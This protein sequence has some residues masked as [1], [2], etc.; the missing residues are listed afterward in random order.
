MSQPIAHSADDPAQESTPQ[1]YTNPPPSIPEQPVPAF[2]PFPARNRVAPSRSGN[3]AEQSRPGDAEVGLDSGPGGTVDVPY[4]LQTRGSLT[5]LTTRQGAEGSTSMQERR[6]SAL[7]TFTPFPAAAP[8]SR[9]APPPNSRAESTRPVL[10]PI[11]YSEDVTSGPWTAERPTNLVGESSTPIIRY[12][13]GIP[14]GRPSPFAPPGPLTA[15]PHGDRPHKCPNCQR[16]FSRKDAVQRH[17]VITKCGT[18]DN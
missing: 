12:P 4:L 5:T 6:L 16:S 18:P 11:L 14:P 8:S 3:F 2:Q 15:R 13:S 10:P 9:Y 1:L 17:I 7:P